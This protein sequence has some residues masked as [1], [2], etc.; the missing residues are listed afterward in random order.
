MRDL[1]VPLP[2]L[3]DDAAVVAAIGLAKA[4]RARLRLS[5]PPPV[6][7][8]AASDG[9]AA[10]SV[11]AGLVEHAELAAAARA[12]ALREQLQ[13]A[14]VDG[15]VLVET[16][17][18][19]APFATMALRARCADLS[20]VVGA[21]AHPH[22]AKAHALFCALL[23][24][25]GRPVLVLPAERPAPMHPYRKLLLAWKPT[26]EAARA[27]HDALAL[28]KPDAVEVLVVDAGEPD[29]GTNIAA[30]LARHGLDVELTPLKRECHVP[31]AILRTARDSDVDGIV[32]GGYGHARLREWV[33]G[34]TTRELFAGLDRAVLFSH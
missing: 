20:M 8:M 3:A 17:R 18:L 34:G 7:G 10:A 9:S 33:L 4:Y 23:F 2:G 21:H 31:Q 19:E 13:A 22:F 28:L 15:E 26:R 24:E 11:L 25:T 32:L 16:V 12:S 27:C 30:H 14:R 29:A 6:F 1:F 5:L